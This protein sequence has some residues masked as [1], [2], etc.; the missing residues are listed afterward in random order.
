MSGNKDKGT[1]GFKALDLKLWK[2]ALVEEMRQM[3]RRELEHLH[4]HLD[5]VENARA[6][7]LQP[8][9]QA[10][11]RE[12]AL[13]REEVNNY[14]GDEYGEEEESVGSH[15]RNGQG[16]RDRNQGDDSCSGIKMK[17]PS[18]HGKF[19]PEAYL[20]WEKKM[21]LVF[22]CRDYSKAQKVKIAV[23]EFTNYAMIWWD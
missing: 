17:V 9:P 6:E 16:K 20:E 19:D 15:R 10:C 3:M 12:G 23:I 2:E 11:G 1:S 18:F 4:E 8:I 14:Y 5:Q 21:E 22:D 7:H 13:V